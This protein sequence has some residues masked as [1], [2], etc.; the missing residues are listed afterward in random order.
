[1][2]PA[3]LPSQLHLP[4][5]LLRAPSI[6]ASSGRAYGDAF[7]RTSALSYAGTQSNEVGLLRLL[8]SQ[9][10]GTTAPLFQIWGE[11]YTVV[12]VPSCVLPEALRLT[13][14]PAS[15]FSQEAGSGMGGTPA[16]EGK[17]MVVVATY[18]ACQGLLVRRQSGGATLRYS[19]QS[20]RASVVYAGAL[21]DSPFGELFVVAGQ[22]P[23]GTRA[24]SAACS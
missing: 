22:Y 7:L 17:V 6:P 3:L 20:R 19:P 9:Q 15:A 18:P 1:M 5:Q 23:C 4:S 24:V 14:L 11:Y 2:P 13:A 10:Y 12:S 8:Y 16:G 21:G